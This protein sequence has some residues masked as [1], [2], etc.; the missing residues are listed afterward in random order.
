MNLD[1]ALSLIYTLVEGELPSKVKPLE[2][3]VCHVY[4]ATGTITEVPKLRWE[5]FRSK[6]LEGEK[7]TPTRGALLPHILRANYISMREKL[8]TGSYPTLL[9]LQDNGWIVE[10]NKYLPVKCLNHPL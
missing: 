6:N 1:P 8:Y 10:D 9:E 5:L 3:F 4:C 7:L 2:K